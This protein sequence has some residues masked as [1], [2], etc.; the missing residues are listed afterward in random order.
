MNIERLFHE[1]IR[2]KKRIGSNIFSRVSTRKG[3]GNQALR[4]P[5]YFMKGSNKYK[6]L[7]GDVE[8]YNLN[9]IISYQEFSDKD[10]SQQK[11]FM[12]TWKAK[13]KAKEIQDKMG[14]SK[15]V[16]YKIIENLGLPTET[17]RG[18]HPK[19]AKPED[20][21]VI[22]SD[23]EM[24]K[25]MDD[26]IDFSLFK[27][28]PKHQQIPLLESYLKDFPVQSELAKV[29]GADLKY[30]YYISSVA[31]KQKKKQEQKEN[32]SNVEVVEE[33]IERKEETTIPVPVEL[34][35]AT[36][37][38]LDTIADETVVEDKPQDIESEEDNTIEETVESQE[39]NI[40]EETRQNE[41]NDNSLTIEI[42][43]NYSTNA[44][45]KSIQSILTTLE[46]EEE[47]INIDLRVRKR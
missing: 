39:D 9:D 5:S 27:Q 14:I 22:L 45:M 47:V 44:I 11:M 7:S 29:W 24:S 25:Y 33:H 1:E 6:K 30:V 37:E 36:D 41:E 32:E 31:R 4:T 16:Y 34:I 38:K 2:D 15:N 26:F 3:G 40:M 23:E 43:G 17:R 35:V 42:K 12:E 13:Y 18:R 21:H 46:D 28:L 19:N 20:L 8:V 10:K